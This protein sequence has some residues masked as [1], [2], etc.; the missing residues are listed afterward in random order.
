MGLYLSI[1]I[2]A[3]AAALQASILPLISLAGGGP[4][5]VFLLV[6]SWALD[7]DVRQGAVWAFVGGLMLD[8]LS[9]LP[10]G[11]HSIPLLMI[12]FALSGIGGQIYRLGLL[13][14]VGM[15]AAGTLF[16]QLTLMTLRLLLGYQV[17][18]VQE[19]TSIVLPTV[20]YN[21]VLIVP[22]YWLVRRVQR[23]IGRRGASSQ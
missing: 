18:W 23:S 13:L 2:L 1:P 20:F 17:V 15:A 5:L 19:F 10:V 21:L 11:T 4:D 16:Q 22:V 7:T 12:V 6:L 8:L 3:L 9:V 14:L